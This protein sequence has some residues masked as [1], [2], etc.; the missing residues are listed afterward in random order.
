MPKYLEILSGFRKWLRAW[1][2]PVVNAEGL[3][4]GT[5]VALGR[6]KLAEA[7]EACA[8]IG[9]GTSGL[10]VIG[11]TADLGSGVV[12]AGVV[13]AGGV[14]FLA[15]LKTSGRGNSEERPSVGEAVSTTFAESIELFCG[16]VE[17]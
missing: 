5:K 6:V 17:G 7:T 1:V 12:G 10:A 14:V 11:A 8:D 15:E 4:K 9:D 13:G 2:T 16:E 3:E